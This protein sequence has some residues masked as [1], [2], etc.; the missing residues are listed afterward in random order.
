MKRNEKLELTSCI[1]M[2][3]MISVLA[4]FPHDFRGVLAL[5]F[6]IVIFSIITYFSQSYETSIDYELIKCEC[7]LFC[8]MMILSLSFQINLS[9][10]LII[11]FLIML[12]TAFREIKKQ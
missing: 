9:Y 2:I 6:G 8:L 3:V 5:L 11:T 7:M 10:L 1:I 4:T 12:A